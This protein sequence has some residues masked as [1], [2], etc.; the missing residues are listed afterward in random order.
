MSLREQLLQDRVSALEEGLRTLVMTIQSHLPAAGVLADSALS[1]I[2]NAH[3]HVER[4]IAMSVGANRVNCRMS[5]DFV[6]DNQR[7]NHLLTIYMPLLLMYDKDAR[8]LKQGR[9][10]GA[11]TLDLN[12][13]PQQDMSTQA[14]NTIDPYHSPACMTLHLGCRGAS[15]WFV[16]GISGTQLHVDE[17][18]S[19]RVDYDGRTMPLFEREFIDVMS[20]I[21]RELDHKE[22]MFNPN[23]ELHG[24]RGVEH[25]LTLSHH[26][27][28]LT[29][30]VLDEAIVGR[31]IVLTPKSIAKEINANIRITLW[32]DN[33]DVALEITIEPNHGEAFKL[34]VPRNSGT[35]SLCAHRSYDKPLTPRDLTILDRARLKQLIEFVVGLMRGELSDL[36]FR[37][38]TG[39]T[40]DWEVTDIPHPE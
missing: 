32:K 10:A 11:Y 13:L 4:T 20:H 23:F 34:L 17:W 3:T 19:Y 16:T 14:H 38:P 39:A 9:T 31:G 29:A 33:P 28:I 36:L 5:R 7:L 12:H 6:L 24:N 1:C 25:A 15:D 22:A 21:L 27:W 26:T 2:D 40:I 37:D 30:K 8:F 18:V 35:L